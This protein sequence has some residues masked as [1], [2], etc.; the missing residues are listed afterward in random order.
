MVSFSQEELQWQGYFSYNSIKDLTASGSTLYAGSENTLFSKNLNSQ[1]LSTLNSIDGFKPDAISAIY[2][3]Q[4][5]NILFVGNT[6]GLLLL[7]LSDGRIVQKRGILDEVPVSPFVK[8]I[9]HFYEFDDKV[10]LSCDYGISAFNLNTLEFGDTF[11]IGNNGQSGKVFQTTVFNNEIYAVTQFDG[12]KKASVTNP[13]LVDYNQ[14]VVFDSFFWNGIATF[15]NQLIIA[16]YPNLYKSN[17]TT[18]TV[19]TTFS[20]TINKISTTTNY[21]VL[22][23]LNNVYVY[24]QALQQVASVQSSQIN[25]P[26]VTFTCAIIINETLFIGTNKIGVV[27]F[28]L[29]NLLSFEPIKPDGPEQNNI[30]RLKKSSTTLWALYGRYNRVYNPYNPPLGLGLFPISTY[31]QESGWSMIPYSDLFG[32]KSL[33]NIAF[34]PNNENELYVSSYYSGLL[35]ILNEVPTAIFNVSNT[36]P[37]GLQA[38]P[39]E[40]PDDIRV[41]GPAFDSNGNL[42]VCSHEGL[43]TFEAP[44]PTLTTTSTSS[45]SPTQSISPTQTVSPSISPSLSHPTSPSTDPHSNSAAHPSTALPSFAWG[46]FGA[47]TGC[48]ITLTA[49]AYIP[50][51]RALF[52]QQA[53][54]QS[55]FAAAGE[56]G[57]YAQLN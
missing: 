36:G 7:V 15:G 11:F 1:T 53:P 55:T 38:I 18:P 25:E 23:T 46:A 54:P 30:F 2:F 26:G 3:S 31:K 57:T 37:N 29:N 43:Y 6:N 28:P 5:K 44:L 13:N 20:E 47:I 48:I 33:S 24:N 17:G 21:V 41:N 32:A 51:L 34:K 8:A 40:V 12:I 27:A 10:Y 45:F 4:T 49:V 56:V 22:Q 50:K 42:Y 16:N 14:W 52:A 9:N 39:G 19:V 35:K